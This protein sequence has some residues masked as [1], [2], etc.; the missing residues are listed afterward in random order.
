MCGWALP[1]G[2]EKN[3]LPDL[4]YISETGDVL[5]FFPLKKLP[6][7]SQLP[8]GSRASWVYDNPLS[9]SQATG[10]VGGCL[11][12]IT[13]RISQHLGGGW[14]WRVLQPQDDLGRP[15]V[16]FWWEKEAPRLPLGLSD[17]LSPRWGL[18]NVCILQPRK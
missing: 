2:I 13:T 5:I 8:L 6:L 3:V 15:W 11:V 18:C 1:T 7:D 17:L 10:E 14:F 4:S 16:T 12:V 9:S